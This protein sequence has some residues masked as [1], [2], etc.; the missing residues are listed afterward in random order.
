MTLETYG[1]LLNRVKEYP[2]G[3]GVAIVNTRKS[4]EGLLENLVSS[5]SSY[6]LDVTG[7]EAADFKE[8]K[9]LKDAERFLKSKGDFGTP[10]GMAIV[11][12]TPRLNIYHKLIY[13]ALD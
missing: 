12:I 7:V 11:L 8:V 5:L 1:E 3:T 6:G 4:R 10:I 9:N 13:N 2:I